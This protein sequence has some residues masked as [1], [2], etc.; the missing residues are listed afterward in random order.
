M[1]NLSKIKFYKKKI[2]SNPK[3]NIMKFINKNDKHYFKF[4]EIYF[5]WIKI[6]EFK[7]WKLHQK[8]QMNL[9]VPYGKVS[10]LFYDEKSK[11]KLVVDLSEK[12][13]GTLYVP[14]KIWFGFKNL[15]KKKNSLVVNFSNIIHN[16]K[17]SIN[18]DFKRL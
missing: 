14:P 18:K 6:N 9:T 1:S 5:T 11:K 17:E 13:F 3:G 7:G 15:S 8:M 10:F 12:K 2:I 16:K 4:G